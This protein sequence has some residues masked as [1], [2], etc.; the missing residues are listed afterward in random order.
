M[1]LPNRP[2]GVDTPAEP[3]RPS[4]FVSGTRAIPLLVAT[5]VALLLPAA[6]S[7]AVPVTTNADEQDGECAL[8]CSLRDAVAIA[9]RT[10]DVVQVPAGTYVLNLGQLDVGNVTIQGA[11][12]GATVV[13]AGVNARALL[14]TSSA[15]IGGVTITGGNPDNA[16]SGGGIE[17]GD[18]QVPMTLRLNDSAV[19][20]NLV[21]QVSQGYGGGIMVNGQ[22]TLLMTNTTVSG[23]ACSEA[24]DRRWRRDLHHH[25][26]PRGAP[27]LDRQRQHGRGGLRRRRRGRRRSR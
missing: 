7:A 22:A 12:A 2:V 25:R 14:I 19:S 17:V 20:G 10:A 1:S 27:E 15:T 3:A 16:N 9:S 18:G 6:A 24:T 11:G 5:L 23:I 13:Q 4:F 8:D 26:R 21:V